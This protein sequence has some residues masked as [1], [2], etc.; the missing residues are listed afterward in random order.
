MNVA[1]ATGYS[2]EPCVTVFRD[3]LAWVKVVRLVE[4][5][6]DGE[7]VDAPILQSS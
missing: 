7:D 4:S 5:P 3:N 2:Y 1:I 6:E